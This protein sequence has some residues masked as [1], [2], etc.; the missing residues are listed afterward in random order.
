MTGVVALE[1]IARAGAVERF[2]RVADVLEG[3][4][5]DEIVGAFQHGG[6]PIVFELLVS[7][8]HRE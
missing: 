4:A 3:I 8:E 5:E 1:L 6:L 2:Q 7:L